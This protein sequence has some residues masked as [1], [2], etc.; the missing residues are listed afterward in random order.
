MKI[1]LYVNKVQNINLPFASTRCNVAMAI[2]IA[3]ASMRSRTIFDI[4]AKNKNIVTQ[5]LAQE[6]KIK[7][8]I[9]CITSILNQY[10]LQI[11]FNIPLSW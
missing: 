7:Y 1:L 5:I 2:S 11:L 9:Y 8:A 6:I 10:Y 3:I 4:Y